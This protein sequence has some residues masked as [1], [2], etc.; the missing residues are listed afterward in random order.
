MLSF[1]PARLWGFTNRGL[2]MPGMMADLVVFD[3]QRVGPAMPSAE[4]D[5]PSGAQRLVQN[6]TGIAATIVAGQVVLRNGSH[7]GALPGRLIRGT[8]A[9]CQ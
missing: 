2:V 6:A 4:T 1:D 3:P 8:L 5:L 7:T 9:G